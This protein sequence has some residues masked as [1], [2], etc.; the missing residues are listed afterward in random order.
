MT[1]V[2]GG[3]DG[4]SLPCRST[5][6]SLR[7]T[8]RAA[9]LDVEIEEPLGGRVELLWVYRGA[10]SEGVKLGLHELGTALGISGELVGGEKVLDRFRLVRRVWVFFEVGL[11]FYGTCG[12]VLCRNSSASHRSRISIEKQP[13]YIIEALKPRHRASAFNGIY[14]ELREYY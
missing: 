9:K 5:I 6:Q 4:S 7:W 14:R 10:G 2:S 12:G 8:Q 11:K 13:A 1:N 3:W